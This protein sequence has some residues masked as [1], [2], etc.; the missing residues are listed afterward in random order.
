M[1]R[2]DPVMIDFEQEPP[3]KTPVLCNKYAMDDLD[4]R[5]MTR[6]AKRSPNIRSQSMP[7]QSGRYGDRLTPAGRADNRSVYDENDIEMQ[8]I[9]NKGRKRERPGMCCFSVA[10]LF[11]VA[12]FFIFKIFCCRIFWFLFHFFAKFR[13]KANDFLLCNL[14]IDTLCFFSFIF[15]DNFPF[16]VKICV[17][18]STH[19]STQEKI[20]RNIFALK[21]YH[22]HYI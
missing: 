11:L 15:W 5:G 6:D 10:L 14:G 12:Q 1:L 17:T 18:F 22:Q 4:E 13:K 8:P 3:C 16:F 20:L 21:F 2:R 9:R 7:R 19:K